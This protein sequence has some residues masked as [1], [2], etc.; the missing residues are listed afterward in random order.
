MSSPSRSLE[1][2]ETNSKI[3]EQSLSNKRNVRFRSQ[4]D[5]TQLAAIPSALS[6]TSTNSLEV[7]RRTS[8]METDSSLYEN[9]L[10]NR[11][12]SDSEDSRRRKKHEKRERKRERML[13]M[14]QQKK[15]INLRPEEVQYTIEQKVPIHIAILLAFQV[16]EA[17]LKFSCSI[18]N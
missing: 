3:S 18:I 5:S 13:L 10:S 17:K 12:S 1:G 16:G 7:A 2:S 8:S 14:F 6:Q 15:G 9:D 4:P 11:T